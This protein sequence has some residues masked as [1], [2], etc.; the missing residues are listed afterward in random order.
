[1]K[2]LNVLVVDDD[3]HT[4]DKIS[5]I[6]NGYKVQF[7]FVEESFTFD[8]QEVESGEEALKVLERETPDIVLLD[9]VMPGIQG[10]DV[11]E[12]INE[13]QYDTAVLL[14]STNTYAS[15]ELALKATK[16]G[17]FDC[18]SKP[19][20]PKELI[21]CVENI[22]RHL[23]LLRM[24]RKMNKEG[25]ELRF[26][27][28]SV[29]SHELKA[30]IN[31]IEGY[32]LMMKD[33]QLGE[34]VDDYQQIIDRCM[35]RI[36]G[37]R[38]LILDLLDLTRI[39]HNSKKRELK[40]VNLVEVASTSIDTL[41]P[42]AIQKDIKINLH[43]DK[44]S[45]IIADENEIEII[46]NNLI[47]NAVKYNKDGGKVDVNIHTTDN[48]STITVSDTGIGMTNEDI[49][50]LFN[51]FVRIKTPKTKHINGTGLGLSIIKKIAEMYDGK[52]NVTSAP[53]K[54][55]VFKVTLQNYEESNN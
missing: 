20:T 45:Y 46:F 53:D 49:S 42:Y 26:Q 2:V 4:R 52:V 17:A 29:L 40:Q 31:A 36:N 30:P 13:K 25:K 21:T 12:H 48:L 38:S 47:S 39:E 16:Y 50:K 33:K 7:S 54:G 18:L 55:S 44:N 43:A 15:L 19:F 41:R 35:Q 24:T 6:L 14:M 51:D 28:L 5:S 10:L 1:M 37:M 22:S 8:I 23:F 32:M 11:L 9:N 27:F 34:H 3:T